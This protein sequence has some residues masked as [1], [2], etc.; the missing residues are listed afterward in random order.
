MNLTNVRKDVTALALRRQDKIR[1]FFDFVLELIE[2]DADCGFNCS[3]I[4]AV[5]QVHPDVI[6]E[7]VAELIDRGFRIRIEYNPTMF[8]VV[9]WDALPLCSSQTKEVYQTCERPPE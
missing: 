7:V 4:H 3:R 5:D 8:L 2:L 1:P 9:S 6:K